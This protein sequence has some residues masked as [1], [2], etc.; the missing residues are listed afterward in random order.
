MENGWDAFVSAASWVATSIG[1]VL[2]FVL[3]LL[4]LAAAGR[5]LW[6]RLRPPRTTSAGTE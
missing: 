2:P 4:V 6:P 3:V 5:I 1:A